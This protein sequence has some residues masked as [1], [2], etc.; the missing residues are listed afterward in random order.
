M[1]PT[2]G[3]QEYVRLR[4]S[5]FSFGVHWCTQEMGLRTRRHVEWPGFV[6]RMREGKKVNLLEDEKVWAGLRFGHGGVEGLMLNGGRKTQGGY[7]M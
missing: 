1:E 4:V 5:P 2:S 3:P 6:L 7:L